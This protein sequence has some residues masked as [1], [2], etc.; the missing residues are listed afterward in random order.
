MNSQASGWS[1][2]PKLTQDAVAIGDL[3]LCRLLL[4]RD[5]N[6]PWLILVPRRPKVTEIIDLTEADRTQLMNEIALVARAL[7][8]ITSCDK[9]NVAALGNVV[10]QL[11]VH[12]I[13]RRRSDAAWPNP[14]WNVVPPRAYR[15]AELDP[16]IGAV[17]RAI[18]LG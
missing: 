12:I 17:R 8:T 15:P 18:D 10:P 14:I 3:P 16:L 2:H 5:A 9:L 1:L 11:H 6:Y 7:R 13:A 4:N